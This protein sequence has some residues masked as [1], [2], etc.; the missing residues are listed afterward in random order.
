MNKTKCQYLNFRFKGFL[1]FTV[2]LIFWRSFYIAHF[3]QKLRLALLKIKNYIQLYKFNQ[4]LFFIIVN[5]YSKHKEKLLMKILNKWHTPHT[6]T[7]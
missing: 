2:I 4:V 5:N 6:Y 7:L 3:I 1:D